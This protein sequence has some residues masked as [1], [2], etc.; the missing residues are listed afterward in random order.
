[1]RDLDQ[2]TVRRANAVA[3][4]CQNLEPLRAQL[5]DGQLGDD[6]PLERVVAAV[7]S[8][9]DVDGAL[10]DLHL[11]LQADGDARGVHGLH[12][13]PGSSRGLTGGEPPGGPGPHQVTG[14][15]RGG[16]PG[17]ADIVYL[18]PAR[19]CARFWAPHPTMPLARCA[20]TGRPLRRDRL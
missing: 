3:Y 4:V 9:G 14:L 15:S 5:L 17:P 2:T 6:A 10:E 18:C 11:L 19:R 1:M 12:D 16:A 13:A 8:G 7:R 20:I